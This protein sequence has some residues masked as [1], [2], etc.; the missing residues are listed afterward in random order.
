MGRPILGHYAPE[1][2]SKNDPV[3]GQNAQSVY[4]SVLQAGQNLLGFLVLW[5]ELILGQYGPE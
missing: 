2:V 1:Y 4:H 5:V 3:M